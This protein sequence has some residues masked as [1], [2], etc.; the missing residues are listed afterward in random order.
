M[1]VYTHAYTNSHVKYASS[2]SWSQWH[3]DKICHLLNMKQNT[4]PG[5]KMVTVCI[6]INLYPEMIHIT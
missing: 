1:Y 4:P 2:T 6:R 5:T 3:K